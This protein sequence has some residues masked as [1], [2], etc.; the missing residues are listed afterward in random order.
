MHAASVVLRSRWF[1]GS[2]IIAAAL[3]DASFAGATP[4]VYR[5]SPACDHDVCGPGI[6]VPLG[7]IGPNAYPGELL[8]QPFLLHQDT[9]IDE[10]DFWGEG[11]GGTFTIWTVADVGSDPPLNLNAPA[12]T[13]SP[14][15]GLVQDFFGVDPNCRG[16]GCPYFKYSVPLAT[17]FLA[18]ANVPYYLSIPTFWLVGIGPFD[19]TPWMLNSMYC[20]VHR[21]VPCPSLGGA[22]E[23]HGTPAPEP[24]TLVLLGSGLLGLM[25]AMRAA[26]AS[27]TK[28]RCA[29]CDPS[30]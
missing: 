13:V 1:P 24:A 28:D 7:S 4:V 8:L 11:F 25:R 9:L 10:I 20:D 23:L 19:G 3:F 6:A 22:F 21:P 12:T 29:V 16:D 15:P 30:R 26:A 5:R 17:P 18:Q 27:R 2:L 14:G